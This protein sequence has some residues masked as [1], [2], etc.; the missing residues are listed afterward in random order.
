MTSLVSRRSLSLF[1]FLFFAMP[2]W[3]ERPP[4]TQGRASKGNSLASSP[5]FLRTAGSTTWVA[6]GQACD[7]TDAQGSSHSSAQVWCFEGAAGDSTWPMVPP[8]QNGHSKHETWDHY[9][10]FAPREGS[11]SRWHVTT[12]HGGASTGA[13][14]AWCGCDSTGASPGCADVHWWIFHEGYGDD[15]NYGLTLDMSG[16][17]AS[18]GGTIRFDLRYDS[19]C[20]YDYTYLEYFDTAASQWAAVTDGTGRAATFNAVSGNPCAG[21]GGTGR[22]CG[23]DYFF[24]SDQGAGG[25]PWYGNSAW[26][27]NVTLPMPAQS[28][29]LQLRWRCF[30][31][32]AFSDQ[33]GRGD[34]DGLAAIDNVRITFAASGV[35]VTDDFET[36]NFNG[37]HAT[38]GSASWLPG[39]LLGNTYDGWH[40][41]FD[42]KYKN[43][44]NTCTYSNDW[45]W[46]SKPAATA[47]PVNGFDYFLVTPVIDVHGWT[48]GVLEYAEYFC[49]PFERAGQKA[50]LSRTYEAGRGWSPWTLFDSWIE[51]SGCYGWQ[52][53]AQLYLTPLL[54]P[55]KD[56]LQVAWEMLDNTHPGDFTWG[57]H[58]SV[59]YLIDDVSIGSYDVTATTF[60]TSSIALFA[61]TFSRVDPA[62]TPALSNKEEGLWLGN[63]GTRPFAHGDSLSVQV[64]DVDGITVGN[65]RIFWRVG[66]GTPPAFGAWNDKAMVYS[67]PDPTS[68]TDE[69]GYRTAIG[70]TTTEDYSA[71]EAGSLGNPSLD[72]IWDTATTVEYYVRVRDNGG[73]LAHFPALTSPASWLRFQ[74]LPFG[75]LAGSGANARRILLVDDYGREGLDFEHSTGFQPQGGAG[76]GSFTNPAYDQDQDMVERALALNYGGSEDFDH[77]A[78][79]QPKWDIYNVQGAGSSIQ[80]EP[81]V[82]ADSVNGLGGIASAVGAPS[83]DA[84][85]WLNGSFDAHC[86]ADTTR[87]E[88]KSFLDHGGHLF[89]T[90]DDV[91]Q[92]LGAA[93]ANADS[94]VDFLGPY[95]GVAFTSVS[96]DETGD[97]VLDV[98]G[99][100]SGS[101]AC[102]GAGL[103]GECPGPRRTFD[104]LTLATAVPGV[105][106]NSVLATYQ[107]GDAATNG[108]AAIIK[109]VR[110]AGDGVAVHCGFDVGCLVSDRARA[111][112]LKGIFEQDFGL[113]PTSLPWADYCCVAGAAPEAGVHTGFDLAEPTPNPAAHS[114][115]VRFSVPARMRVTLRVYDVLGRAVRTLADEP[116]EANVYTREWDGRTDAGTTVSS[117]VY[118][119][120]MSAGDF[121][122]TRKVV[123]LK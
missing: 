80:R 54:G 121:T 56:S 107:S 95:L 78:Y 103:Y 30:S 74:V 96:D 26:L 77:G 61:D 31:D 94:V 88:L 60:G 10:K 101:L 81:R 42:P 53:N 29:G 1:L 66:A 92:Y 59:I 52:V 58:R 36:G 44:G 108:R 37:V 55:G 14:N 15:W 83:Y 122:A 16:Q 34:T 93:G 19:E 27:T 48:G 50:E 117:G 5:T 40:L 7:T 89:S 25:A 76:Y 41:E 84:V 115:V 28:G 63:G 98:V 111:C 47:I 62:H 97:K 57:D 32:G 87:L 73:Q 119:V 75:R 17:N 112:L 70:N 118:F 64:D 86:F 90:G 6:V 113:P 20:G 114:T 35:V 71:E 45:M 72:P 105:N 18:S 11:P 51:D 2:A 109:N 123:R 99:E 104:K 24:A 67:V 100:R 39:A 12:R 102:Y 91:A 82:R 120:R 21:H 49:T 8:G 23:A 3:A 68:P 116:M 38:G 79:G 43:K 33:D 46:S 65:V 9:S 106:A 110:I 4:A 69:G 13:F 85:I 22:C